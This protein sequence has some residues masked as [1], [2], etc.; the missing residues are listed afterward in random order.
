M[1]REQLEHA[2]M[3]L[4]WANPGMSSTSS[5]FVKREVRRGC[6]SIASFGC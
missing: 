1:R 3:A 5:T 4:V 6:A 2:A